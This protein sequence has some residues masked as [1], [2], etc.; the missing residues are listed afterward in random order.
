MSVLHAAA[1]QLVVTAL[2]NGGLG[3]TSFDVDFEGDW[4]PCKYKVLAQNNS[5]IEVT[6]DKGN[7]QVFALTL[8]P[9]ND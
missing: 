9:I 1:A 4:V 8:T 6:D 7:K 2:E 5:V 3:P